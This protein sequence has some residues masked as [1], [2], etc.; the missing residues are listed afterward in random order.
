MNDIFIH[1][2]SCIDGHVKIGKY[3][4]IAA[5]SVVTKDVRPYALDDGGAGQTCRVGVRV[6]GSG[7]SLKLIPGK[8]HTVVQNVTVH[9][10]VSVII[11]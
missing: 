11:I 7:S 3:T 4:M 2:S 9:I 10:T 8:G 5:G 6:R 1:E